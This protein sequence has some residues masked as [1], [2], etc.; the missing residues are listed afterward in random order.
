VR[1]AGIFITL[2]SVMVILFAGVALA[3]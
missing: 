3:D 2:I 1:R